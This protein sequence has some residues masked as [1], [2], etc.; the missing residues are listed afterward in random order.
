MR[1]I[2]KKPEEKSGEPSSPA[3]TFNPKIEA[4][5]KR[6]GGKPETKQMLPEAHLGLTGGDIPSV[7]L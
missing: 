2:T 5:K 3:L 1:R 4:E 7:M 6:K